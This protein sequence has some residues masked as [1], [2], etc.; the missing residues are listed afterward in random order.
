LVVVV[1]TNKFLV[2]RKK[3]AKPE[4]PKGKQKRIWGNGGTT[5]DVGS[6]DFSSKSGKSPTTNG[7]VLE[8]PSEEQVRHSFPHNIKF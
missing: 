7:E 5:N 8:E 4:K 6:L 3:S 2:C 1:R